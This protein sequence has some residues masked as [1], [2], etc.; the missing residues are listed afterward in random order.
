[1]VNFKQILFWLAIACLFTPFLVNTNT[2]FPYII[3]KAT[4]FRVLVEIMFVLWVYWLMVKNKEKVHLSPL[5]KAILI[6]GLVIFV[7]ALVGVNFYW[8]FFSGNERMEGVFGIWHFI[9]FFVILATTFSFEELKNLIKTQVYLGLFYSFIALLIYFNLG[10]LNPQATGNRLAGFTGNPSYYATYLLFNAFF[11]LYF[12]FEE[13]RFQKKLFTS[14]LLIFGVFSIL[15]FLTGCR[16]VMIGYGISLLI[17]GLGIIFKKDKELIALKKLFISVF[18][19]GLIFLIAVFSLKNTK[20]VKGNFALERLTAISFKDPTAVSRIYSAKTAF[21]G[22]LEKPLFG[23]GPENYQP[24]YIKY[25]NP[26]VIKYLPTDFFFDRAHNK[27]ME[28]LATTGIFG[29]ISYL[30]IFFF[31]FFILYQRQKKDENWFISSLIFGSLIFGYFV[32]NA[33]IFDFH[34][35]YLMFFLTLAF[36]NCFYLPKI[37]TKNDLNQ[38]SRFS[39]YS[40]DLFKFF[41][42]I[43]AMCLIS[44]SLVFWVFQPYKVSLLIIQGLKDIRL[45]KPDESLKVF[46]RIIQSP[47]FLKEDAIIGYSRIID[48]YGREVTDKEKLLQLVDEVIKEANNILKIHK[49][50]YLLLTSKA[51]LEEM[52]FTLGDKTKLNEAE[53]SL[54]KAIALAP[55]FPQ[56]RILYSRLLLINGKT[57]EAISQLEKIIELNPDIPEA[58]YFYY[59]AL[60]A[61]NEKEKALPYLIKAI[62][63]N[64]R[65]LDKNTIFELV[66]DLV[67]LKRYD[68]I[69]KLY[70]QALN[71]DPQDPQICV[72][73]AATYGK[74]HNKEKAIYYAQKA[75]ELSPNLKQAVQ[76]FIELIQTGQWDKIPD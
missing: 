50:R 28:V 61:K 4:V 2:Y 14:W 24:A 42:T 5:I 53:E 12:Y 10:P 19:L 56:P 55:S 32:Q 8:S 33:F 43:L 11:A 73:L 54:K 3:T 68:L 29:F 58:N 21:K 66:K 25:F 48:S 47:S 57:D 74:M 51:S 30:S 16:G 49:E 52:A 35:S 20:L 63:G 40:K 9:L 7:S 59:R 67:G 39:D 26:I 65:L 41:V 36:I 45:N 69:E 46:K 15:M 38:E 22:F 6:Y 17:V 23:W 1:M 18:V 60:K 70:L 72:S 62:E 64:V 37:I 44:Y 27:P 71:L 75:A 34:E 76:N 13:F 31:A